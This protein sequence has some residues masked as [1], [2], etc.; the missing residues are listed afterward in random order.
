MDIITVLEVGVM[1]AEVVIIKNNG[2]QAIDLGGWVL[3]DSKGAKYTFPAVTVY[4][5]GTLQVH[6]ATRGTDT[7]VDLYWARQPPSWETGEIISLFDAQGVL[8][9]LYTIP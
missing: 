8:Q 5:Q 6:T 2:S 9:A 4:P 7:P 3:Q 1:D